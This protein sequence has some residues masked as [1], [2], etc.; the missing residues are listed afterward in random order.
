MPSTNRLIHI[1]CAHR[2]R[3]GLA[4]LAV[5][6]VATSAAP[7]ADSVGHPSGSATDPMMRTRT[8]SWPP[9]ICPERRAGRARPSCEVGRSPAAMNLSRALADSLLPMATTDAYVALTRG[10]FYPALH[11]IAPPVGLPMRQ[12]IGPMTLPITLYGNGVFVTL[13]PTIYSDSAS[14]V[15]IR[16]SFECLEESGGYLAR[17]PWPP[18]VYAPE[19]LVTRRGARLLREG[20]WT[21]S[22]F[23]VRRVTAK[24]AINCALPLPIPTD[25]TD[26]TSATTALSYV[27][28]HALGHVD[29][30]V[31]QMLRSKDAG[32]S[33]SED[34]TWCLARRVTRSG[35]QEWKPP[36]H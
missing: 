30:R 28:L 35:L 2:L 25:S 12:V 19:T 22:K 1:G 7:Q 3:A 18:A 15:L 8:S 11:S 27:I 36:I 21:I 31:G 5:L 20:G 14:S 34:S 24:I 26:S 32:R 9:V 6:L 13:S 16:T 33:R 29:S 23:D 17:P 4:Q 10:A